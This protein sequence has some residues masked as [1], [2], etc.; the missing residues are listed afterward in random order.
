MKKV[1]VAFALVIASIAL[2]AC[3]SSSSS[4]SSE[5][6][7]TEA[8]SESGAAAG[9]GA[10]A[11]AEGKSANSASTVKIEAAS[12]GLAYTSKTA[13]A[14]AGK[15]TIDFNNPQSLSHDVAIES[16]KGEMVGQTELVAEGESSTVV[17]LKPGTYKF[18]C[19]VPGHREAGMEGTLTVK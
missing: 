2:V 19:T 17:N 14:K 6:T 8:T 4:S 7:A 16:S 10:E 11:E 9:G 1:A 12:S 15:V 13:T 3:G 5:S 18:F